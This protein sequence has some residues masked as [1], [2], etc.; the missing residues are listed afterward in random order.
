MS[1]AWPTK[2]PDERLDYTL[3]WGKE[4]SKHN[5]SIFESYWSIIDD[6]N[7]LTIENNGISGHFTYVWLTDGVDKQRYVLM[8]RIVTD[9]G[10]IY[11]RTVSIV[12]Q[13]NK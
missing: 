7:T 9:D 13:D 12:I 11:E 4:L 2:D 6:D 3:N 5:D 1:R 10:R 8:N